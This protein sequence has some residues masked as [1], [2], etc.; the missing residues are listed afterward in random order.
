MLGVDLLVYTVL[1]CLPLVPDIPNTSEIFVKISIEVLF[2]HVL[3]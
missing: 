1:L 2:C 3:K